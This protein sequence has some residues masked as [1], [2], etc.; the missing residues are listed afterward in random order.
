MLLGPLSLLAGYLLGAVPFGYLLVRLRKGYDVR[1]TGSGSIG[2]TNVTR[3]MGWAG[4][5]L[6][7]LLD[8]GKGYLAVQLAAWLTGADVRWTAA[9]GV[10]ALVGHSYPVYIRFRG[11]KSVATGLGVFVYF[12]PL[13]VAAVLGVWIVVVALWRYVALGSVLAAA[14]FPVF[15]YAL[16]R[17]E[18]AVSLAAVASACLIVL[19]HRSNLQNLARG[20]EDKLTFKRES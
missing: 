18:L 16:Y 8:A 1:T 9:G 4:G 7:L 2:A 15:A 3:T 19:R 14:A 13:A 12:A 20:T 17:P 6:I 10:A 11:G 5:L